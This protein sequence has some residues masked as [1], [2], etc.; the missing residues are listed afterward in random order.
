MFHF[1]SPKVG[2]SVERL[3][4]AGT[5]PTGGTHAKTKF[6]W[7]GEAAQL[8]SDEFQLAYPV[9]V[10][11]GETADL[12][13]FMKTYEQPDKASGRPGL[14]SVKALLPPTIADEIESL[15]A[16]VQKAQ[17][18]YLMAVDAKSTD[19]LDRARFVLGEISKVLEFYLDDGVDDENDVRLARV[20]AAHKDDSSAD[21][22]ALALENFADLATPHRKAIDGLGDFDAALLDEAR[23]LAKDLRAIVEPTAATATSKVALAHRNRLLQ[24]LDARIRRVRSAARFVFRHHPEIARRASSAYEARR[25]VEARRAA[26]KK[27][28]EDPTPTP[29][30]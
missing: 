7:A 29:D 1:S 25:R 28:A 17:A 12:V 8:S 9:A 6:D 22:L 4:R 24:L 18:A 3:F 21:A 30:A 15:A 5:P 16:E 10:Y 2:A 23:T 20:A 26:L 27:K 19:T 13:Q 11:L 14:S